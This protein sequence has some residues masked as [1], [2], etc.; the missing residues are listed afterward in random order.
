MLSQTLFGKKFKNPFVLPSGILSSAEAVLRKAI[1][2]GCGSVATKSTNLKGK[3][4]HPS[5]NF[6]QFEVGYINAVGL[7]NHGVKEEVKVVNKI[8]SDTDAIVFFSIFGKDVAEF[9]QVA[10]EASKSKTDFIEVNISCP[11]VEKEYGLPF[12]FDIEKVIEITKEVKKNSDKPVFVKLSPNVPSVVETAKAAVEGGADGITAINTVGPGML[13]DINK[14]E[15]KITNVVGGVSGPAIKPV[16]LKCVYQIAKEVNV[17][18]IG[19]GGIETAEDAIGML[20]AGASLI[21]IGSA[22][23]SK[24]MNV[25]KEVA[26][27][28]EKYLKDKNYESIS[29]IIGVV[30]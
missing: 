21:G 3:E 5:P 27:D 18:I 30:K 10:K 24:G 29:E 6:A 15:P 20:M 13:I 8:K 26:K 16:A 12:A 1:A 19:T 14:K 22:T 9:G 7:K 23:Y 28:L 4:G 2:S 25:F 11:N 17:P